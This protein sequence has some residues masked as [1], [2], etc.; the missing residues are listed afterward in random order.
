MKNSIK[1]TLLSI[2]GAGAITLGALGLTGCSN[3]NK[4]VCVGDQP[5][6]FVEEQISKKEKFEKTPCVY[7]LK[8][9]DST[10]FINSEKNGIEVFSISNNPLEKEK[11]IGIGYT[12]QTL[13]GERIETLCVFQGKQA[14]MYNSKDGKWSKS[15][16]ELEK[17]KY[18]FPASELE[19]NVLKFYSPH[20]TFFGSG[21]K[22]VSNEEV[23]KYLDLL[24]QVRQ[25]YA[26]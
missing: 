10:T 4:Y 26:E 19:F 15:C 11:T 14:T 18:Y 6:N 17:F 13:F 24:E 25:T 8:E 5:Y 1:N 20:K 3:S 2:V 21:R 9:G 16:G 22:K 7:R 12:D 23:R